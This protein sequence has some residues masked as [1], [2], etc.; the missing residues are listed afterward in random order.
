MELALLQ[1]FEI[2]THAIP[3]HLDSPLCL[4]FWLTF[5]QGA[6]I[7]FFLQGTGR[8]KTARRIVYG[9]VLTLLLACEIACQVVT[10]WD[11][12]VPV[13]LYFYLLALL[14]GAGSCTFGLFL[15]RKRK[16]K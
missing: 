11:L 13:L 12:L 5:L 7:A 10:G 15:L 14:L 2:G 9:L 6:A 16:R 1:G 8:R 3:F 4:V